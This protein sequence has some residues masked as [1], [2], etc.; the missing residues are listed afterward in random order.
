MKFIIVSAMMAILFFFYFPDF[1][2]KVSNY[3]FDGT[4]FPL[5]EDYYYMVLYKGIYV[6]AGAII[7]IFGLLGFL[8][9]L[10]HIFPG[11]EKKL[12]KNP[13]LKQLIFLGVVLVIGPGLVVHQGFKDYWGRERPVN[14]TQFGGVHEY[15]P[16][17]TPMIEQKG[18][19]FI[20]GHA[21]MGFYMCALAFL[22]RG[23]KRHIVYALGFAFGVLVS[24]ARIAQG[25]HYLSDTLFSAIVILFIIHLMH[26]A[27]FER[28]VKK[29]KRRMRAR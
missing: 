4:K 3:F 29:I 8:K 26:F 11:L 5:R 13:T 20:S 9:F 25:A 18:K 19:S 7:F 1:D 28:P 22:F 24:Y 21:A 16:P 10:G 6:L 14:I 23:R 27:M 12:P 17:L 15:S 2:L